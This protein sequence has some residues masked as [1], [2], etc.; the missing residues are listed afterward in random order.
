M[1]LAYAKT[2]GKAKVEG[3]RIASNTEVRGLAIFAATDGDL[4]SSFESFLQSLDIP[5]FGGLFPELI[6][7]GNEIESGAV[8]CGLTTTPDVTTVPELSNPEQE[9]TAHLDPDLPG[10]GYE[11]AFVFVDAYATEIERFV[12]SLF[13]TYGVEFNY[14]GGGA[15]TLDT[16]QQPCLFTGNGIVEGGAVVAAIEPELQLGV[17]HGWKEIAGPFRVTD[18][19]K[20]TLHA[21][22]GTPAFSIYKEIVGQHAP[23]EPTEKKFFEI[24]KG[25]PF[26]IARIE[27][28]QIVRDPFEVTDE[29]GLSC[30][31]DVPEGEFVHILNGQPESLIDAARQA[32]EQT[33]TSR[34]DNQVLFFFDCI[35]RVLYL[36]DEFEQELESVRTDEI[37]T[38]GALTIGEIAN[39]GTGHLDYY[40]K[41][42][43]VGAVDRI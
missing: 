20:R 32:R 25:Y 35:S 21:L 1:K 34:S 7:R 37:P 17:K 38:V 41:T 8:I 31:G 23:V 24:A 28:E 16:E 30:F 19:E 33:E 26:G 9:Y 15:G 27:G 5:V 29:G 40:N 22:D 43:V 39:D 4:S 12:E 6:Y 13:R 2:I 11:T 3:E 18:A 10:D 14:L 42:A 36:E